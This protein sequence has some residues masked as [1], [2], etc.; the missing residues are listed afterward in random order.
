[1]VDYN[2]LVNDWLWFSGIILNLLVAAALLLG[3]AYGVL[4]YVGSV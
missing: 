1:M 3:F 2:E 4:A